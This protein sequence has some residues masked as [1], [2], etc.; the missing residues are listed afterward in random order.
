MAMLSELAGSG[1]VVIGRQSALPFK[2]LILIK[3]EVAGYFNSNSAAL[4]W[5]LYTLSEERYGE[6]RN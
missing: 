2:S 1:D 4:E 3:G 6:K 5:L